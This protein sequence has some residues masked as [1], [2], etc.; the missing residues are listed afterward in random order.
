MYIE[1]LPILERKK[2]HLSVYMY[3]YIH[4]NF[5][6]FILKISLQVMEVFVFAFL[7][8]TQRSEETINSLQMFIV[9]LESFIFLS[10]IPILFA[11][12]VCTLVFLLSMLCF[13]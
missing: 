12:I 3:I 13:G 11:F 8:L 10:N 7:K 6:V 1:C 9:L 2:I 5:S 4:F